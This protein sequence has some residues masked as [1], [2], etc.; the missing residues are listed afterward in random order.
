M[1]LEL[2]P[3][4][5]G[6]STD[7]LGSAVRTKA[8]SSWSFEGSCSP[9]SKTPVG[10][11]LHLVSQSVTVNKLI[12]S[13]ERG[14]VFCSG[15]PVGVLVLLSVLVWL[16]LSKACIRQLSYSILGPIINSPDW[17][18]LC[19]FSVFQTNFGFW[20][21]ELQSVLRL[22]GLPSGRPPSPS[23]SGRAKRFVSSSKL[24][25]RFCGPTNLLFNG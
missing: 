3:S 21:R 1:E 10:H 25:D 13:N 11:I 20:V 19:F 4:W 15:C 6:L 22:A 7:L 2:L 14:N 8:T 23:I 12:R 5:P 18:V 17:R 24:S 9:I 16:S